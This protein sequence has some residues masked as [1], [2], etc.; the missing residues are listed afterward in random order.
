MGQPR[1]LCGGGRG[2]FYVL[3]AAA[4]LPA[5]GLIVW[6]GGAA[7]R[8]AGKLTL[9]AAL[10]GEAFLLAAIVLLAAGSPDQTMLIRDGVAALAASPF[11]DAVIA[12]VILGFGFKIGLVPLHGWMPLSYASGPLFA[13]AALSGATSKAGLIGLIRFLPFD[14]ALEGWGVFLLVFGLI[15]AFYGVA[16]G[17]L[18]SNPRSV[19]AY[20]S[21]SQFGQMAATLGAGLAAGSAGAAL[22][23]SFYAFYH[24]LV[25]G[26][27]FLAADALTNLRHGR[28]RRL[29][30]VT[31]AIAALGF[32][33]FPLAGGALA[34]LAI[35][36]VI[37]EGLS[38]LLF[39]FAACGSTLLMLQFIRLISNL[40]A[41]P[42]GQAG[43]RTPA[44][45]WLLIFVVAMLGPWLLF[46][47]VT[48]LSPSYAVQPAVILDLGW[49]IMVGLLMGWGISAMGRLPSAHPTSNATT[50][51]DVV[52]A[53]TNRT[54]HAAAHVAERLATVERASRSWAVAS[55]A[56]VFVML[57]ITILLAQ[58]PS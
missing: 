34:K 44:H 43:L 14:T 9:A 6:E 28:M 15:S 24:V 58:G 8:W 32:A 57:L 11:R 36:P 21:V 53:L 12:L 27:L 37:G 52:M 30:L 23:V 10:L 42:E 46:A 16:I 55:S 48:G 25:K 20:S 35:K 54:A 33:G 13:A 49:P 39:A 38:G 50:H 45:A 1:C 41:V 5:Y 47:A 22:M 56:L 31:A 40:P 4:S 17:L 18:Q 7:E 2:E 3:Y 19:L 26:G 29:I 51:A